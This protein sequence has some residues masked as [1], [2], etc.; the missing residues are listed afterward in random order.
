MTDVMISL[1]WLFWFAVGTAIVVILLWF[2]YRMQC[3][4]KEQKLQQEQNA[5]IAEGPD[6]SSEQEELPL[7]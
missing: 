6:H 3:V 4:R 5:E 7:C 2:C 1:Q